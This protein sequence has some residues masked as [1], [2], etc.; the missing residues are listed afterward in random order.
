MVKR[1]RLGY[2]TIEKKKGFGRWFALIFT[3]EKKKNLFN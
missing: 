2:V 1:L 3:N